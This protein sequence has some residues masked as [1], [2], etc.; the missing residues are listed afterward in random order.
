MRDDPDHDEDDEWKWEAFD[1]APKVAAALSIN[2][3][4]IGPTTT[5]RGTPLIAL[6]PIGVDDGVPSGAYA[7]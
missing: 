5:M 3:M 4:A 1:L 7:I 6:T 2:P